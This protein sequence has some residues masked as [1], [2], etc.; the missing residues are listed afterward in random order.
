MPRRV[1]GPKPKLKN[2]GKLLKRLMGYILKG[3]GIALFIVIICIFIGVL[4]NVQGTMFMK[5]LVDEYILPLLG[6]ASP[7]FAPLAGAIF[8]VAVFYGSV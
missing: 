1:M 4:A 7:D 2:P 5:T 6:S 3:Y 8:R